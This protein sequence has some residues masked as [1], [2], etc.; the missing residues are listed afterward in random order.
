MI[1]FPPTL[2]FL[3]FCLFCELTGRAK[4][5]GIVFPPVLEYRSLSS[6]GLD[7]A[8]KNGKCRYATILVAG[9][10]VKIKAQSTEC[11]SCSLQ[12]WMAN[13]NKYIFLYSFIWKK[14]KSFLSHVCGCDELSKIYCC[15]QQWWTIVV[16]RKQHSL[17]PILQ[18]LPN[19]H[20][21][22]KS[23]NDVKDT[24]SSSLDNV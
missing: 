3:C 9:Y 18:M 4:P 2:I 5:N 7:M 21:P 23:V 15:W 20:S 10:I 12:Q 13:N 19:G 16:R 24:T 14:K 11:I 1:F 8:K 6:A 17:T 22:T